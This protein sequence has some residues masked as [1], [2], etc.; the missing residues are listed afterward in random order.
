MVTVDANENMCS[1]TAIC[2][3]LRNRAG[4]SKCCAKSRAIMMKLTGTISLAGGPRRKTIP[5]SDLT[6]WGRESG[7]GQVVPRELHQEVKKEGR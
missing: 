3:R 2:E 7:T 1:H 6:L 4:R 5:S